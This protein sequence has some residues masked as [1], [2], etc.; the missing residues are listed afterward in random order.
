MSKSSFSARDLAIAAGLTAFSAV[1]Q[2]IHVGYQSPQFGM[3]IDIVAV[4]WV[5]AFFLFG[6]RMSL[7]VSLG[8][9]IVITLFAPDTWLGASMKW[10]ASFPMWLILGLWLLVFRKNLTHFSKAVNLIIPVV[11]ALALRLALVIPLN[12][13]YAIPIWTG[14]TTAQA[15]AAIPWGVIAVFNIVQGVVDVYIAWILVNKFRLNR[16]S[17]WKKGI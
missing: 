14:M 12:Y 16:F 11:V 8:G 7:L 10:V 13:F 2:L 6:M 3:W 5:M 1:V 15:M 9:A 4:T 17:N